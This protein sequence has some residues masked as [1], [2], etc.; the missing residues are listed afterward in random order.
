MTY[1][2]RTKDTRSLIAPTR[3]EAVV[4]TWE[5]VRGNIL[6]WGLDE[7]DEIHIEMDP[8]GAYNAKTYH[9]RGHRVWNGRGSVE[10]DSLPASLPKTAQAARSAADGLRED[11]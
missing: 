8:A 1:A 7:Y 5:A 11:K 3:Y 10:R 9:W 6:A 2:V 4:H